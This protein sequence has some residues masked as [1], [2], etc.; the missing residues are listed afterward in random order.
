MAH[1]LTGK[2]KSKLHATKGEEEGGYKI[3]RVRAASPPAPRFRRRSV[4]FFFFLLRD[5]EESASGEG[6]AP[7]F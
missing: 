1:D 3:W 2:K 5:L 6:G 4:Y 7:M